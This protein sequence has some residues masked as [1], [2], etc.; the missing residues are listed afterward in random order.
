MST[1]PDNLFD[2][3]NSFHL[4]NWQQCLNEAAKVKTTTDEQ[5]LERDVF[6]YRAYIAQKKFNVVL[7]EINNSSPQPL[8]AVRLYARY[9]SSSSSSSVDDILAELDANQTL[10]M[11]DCYSSICAAAIYF[12]ERNYDNVLKMLNNSGDIECMA[13]SVQALLHL[14]RLD[15]ARKE[16]KRMCQ[17]DEYHTLSQLALAWINLYYG[18]EKLQDAYFI[19]QE[20]KDKFGPTPLLLNG[21]A[22]AMICQ[23]RWEEAEPLIT[24]TIE[25]DSNYTEAIINQMLLA[26]IN[27]KS[28]EMINRYINQLSDRQ[29]LDQTFYD[30]YEHKQREFDKI[31]LQYQIV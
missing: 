17:K 8:K 9:L 20:L 25:K 21:Q 28:N 13:T 29:S 18:G 1:G 26:N 4:G 5:K 23:N 31:A 2:L 22:V 7:S 11:N 10:Y 24:E 19:Y 16:H 27:G 3:K 30:D 14:D 15:L 12:H 6:M